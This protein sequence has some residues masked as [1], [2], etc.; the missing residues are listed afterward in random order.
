MGGSAF[1][2]SPYAAALTLDFVGRGFGVYEPSSGFSARW[3][4]SGDF[5]PT[6]TLLPRVENLAKVLEIRAF[7][8]QQPPKMG[9]CRCIKVCPLIWCAK[10]PQ[11]RTWQSC[12]LAS[13]SLYNSIDE[14]TRERLEKELRRSLFLPFIP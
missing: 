12:R 6:R 11:I 2:F 4:F 14:N 3:P 10:L 7:T 8:Q 9:D 5:S 13:S 1:F